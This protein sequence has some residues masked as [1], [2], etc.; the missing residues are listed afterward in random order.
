MRNLLSPNYFKLSC[1]HQL[2]FFL[3]DKSPQG[4][5]S[6]IHRTVACLAN[7]IN[8]TQF[9]ERL[10]ASGVSRVHDHSSHF[11][12]PQW[13]KAAGGKYV[14]KSV[15]ACMPNL[16][17]PGRFFA[18]SLSLSCMGGLRAVFRLAPSVLLSNFARSI[19]SRTLLPLIDLQ[20]RLSFW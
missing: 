15:R 2:C 14:Y 6:K 5:Y 7:F 18:L 4:L 19:S 12:T 8:Q 17:P 11:Y 13:Q 1:C 10:A 9:G 3:C 16:R 20:P